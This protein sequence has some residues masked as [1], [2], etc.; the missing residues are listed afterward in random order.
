MFLVSITN[1]CWLW[2]GAD[3]TQVSALRASVGQIPF[4]FQIGKDAKDIPLAKPATGAGEL[5][6]RIGT[7]DGPP[8]AS[9]RSR[10]REHQRGHALLPSITLAAKTGAHDLC[11]RFTRASIDPIWT[12]RQRRARGN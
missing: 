3:L 10:G 7:C 12:H 5:E 2:K 9:R 11:L 4:N 6:V 8:A 1:P